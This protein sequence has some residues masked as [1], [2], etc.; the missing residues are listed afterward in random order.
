MPLTCPLGTGAATVHETPLLLIDLE[1]G[2]GVTGRTYRSCDTPAIAHMLDNAAGAV[3]G[4]IYVTA[5]EIPALLSR[6]RSDFP[7]HFQ[8]RLA[9]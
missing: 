7:E 1:T 6:C 5:A 9:G 4:K 2:E 3:R 8:W